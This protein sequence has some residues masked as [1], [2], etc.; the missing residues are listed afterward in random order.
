MDD[1]FE[2]LTTATSP[3]LILYFFLLELSEVHGAIFMVTR[4]PSFYLRSN[5]LSLT[6][7]TTPVVEADGR[8]E[9]APDLL[10]AELELDP[11]SLMLLYTLFPFTTEEKLKEYNLVTDLLKAGFTPAP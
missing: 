5:E 2:P 4:D 10:Q 9:A 1:C 6:A 11:L 7:T 3:D 8:D